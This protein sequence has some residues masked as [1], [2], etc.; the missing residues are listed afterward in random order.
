[1]IFLK[2]KQQA[3]RYIGVPLYP[4]YQHLLSVIE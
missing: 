4:T 3:V 2:S 1:M